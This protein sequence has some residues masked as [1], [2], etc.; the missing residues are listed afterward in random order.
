MLAPPRLPADRAALPLNP[1]PPKALLLEPNPAPDETERLPM[2][3]APPLRFT[4]IAPAPPP[5][6]L[7]ALIFPAPT[8]PP[9]RLPPLIFPAPTPPPGR[10]P[11]PR[12][13]APT[14]PARL[15]PAMP[16]PA[17]PPP[18]RALAPAL[19]RAPAPSVPLSPRAVPPYLFAVCLFP[20]GAFPRCCGLCC[21]AL[22]WPVPVPRL[23]F[24]F[25]FLLQL[26]LLLMF[27]SP[28]FQSQLPQ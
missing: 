20:Y 1:P 4:G 6:R 14:P 22:A 23:T 3:F 7:P 27:T 21:H 25:T 2:P 12:F 5:G 9:G 8:P 15:P 19:P 24:L 18:C 11:A 28:C 17:V 16:D 10:L 26:L 13:C